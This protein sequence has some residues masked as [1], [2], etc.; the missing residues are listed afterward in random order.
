MLWLNSRVVLESQNT[1]ASNTLNTMPFNTGFA[2]IREDFVDGMPKLPII[3]SS[4]THFAVLSTTSVTAA[5]PMSERRSLL[6]LSVG[7]VLDVTGDT[8]RDL[9][10]KALSCIKEVF[11]AC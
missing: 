6:N 11:P 3:D 1:V 10:L 4:E 7:G 9:L 2:K 5:V 8:Y